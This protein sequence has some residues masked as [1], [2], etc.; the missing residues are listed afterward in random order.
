MSSIE[1][2]DQSQVWRL[3]RPDATTGA[4]PTMETTLPIPGVYGE[5]LII[6]PDGKFRSVSEV[7]PPIPDGFLK[8]L[9]NQH[10]YA[11]VS[12]KALRVSLQSGLIP[13]TDV[14]TQTWDKN[15]P[16]IKGEE[17]SRTSFTH[18]MNRLRNFLQQHN[19]SA[20]STVKFTPT[21]TLL[22]PIEF[23]NTPGFKFVYPSQVIDLTH[24]ANQTIR[25]SLYNIC[26]FQVY[27]GKTLFR[28][29]ANLTRQETNLMAGLVN[30]LGSFATN[31]ELFNCLHLG[32][33]DDEGVLYANFKDMHEVVKKVRK[34]LLAANS[35][36]VIRSRYPNDGYSLGLA[37]PE[38]N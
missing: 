19:W 8:E 36:L 37:T 24:V 33:C 29:K 22:A 12:P 26:Y 16:T 35:P 14:I 3:L 7:F 17:K 10:P 20:V 21:Y 23:L 15:P 27:P 34:K 6:D 31:D 11:H 32:N 18:Y 30:K 9:H 25:E 1:S 28:L 2:F 5:T 4:P 38:E 13:R